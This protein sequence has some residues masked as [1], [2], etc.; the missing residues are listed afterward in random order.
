MTEDEIR[1]FQ[2]AHYNHLGRPLQVDGLR[3]PQ[4]NWSLALESLHP[5]R[6]VV[7]RVAQESLGLVEDPPGSNHDRDGYIRGWLAR[8]GAAAG[9]PWCAAFLSHC[10]SWAKDPVTIAGAQVLGKRYPAISQP[11]AGDFFWFPTTGWQGH[12]GLVIG[13]SPTE[14]MTIE[15]NCQNAVRCVRRDRAGL[16]FSRFIA[17]TDGEPPGIVPSVPPAPGGTR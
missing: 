11:I 6:Q 13:T 10:M 17:D 8:C 16:N 9:Q 7:V 2:R 14:V 12:C 3:G 5:D 1:E 15:G 4:T